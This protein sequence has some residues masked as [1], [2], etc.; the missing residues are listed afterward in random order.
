MSK[1]GTLKELNVKAGDVVRLTTSPVGCVKDGKEYEIRSKETYAGPASC[2]GDIWAECDKGMWIGIDCDWVF[3]LVSRA[4]PEPN[5]NDGR[6]HGWNGG[7][8]PV[9][10]ETVVV[11]VT[12]THWPLIHVR[13]VLE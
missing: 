9:H 11:V 6:W 5:Y 10:P 8:C 2:K 3:T 7:E 13:E 1:R 4:T 12:E